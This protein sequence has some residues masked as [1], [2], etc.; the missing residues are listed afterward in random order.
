MADVLSIAQQQNSMNRDKPVL[1]DSGIPGA[2]DAR[3]ASPIPS[4]GVGGPN[5]Y[6]AQMYAI[7]KGPGIP[8]RPLMAG[9]EKTVNL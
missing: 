2:N 7:Q 1:G 3:V 9:S 8:P 6:L 5:R 4:T